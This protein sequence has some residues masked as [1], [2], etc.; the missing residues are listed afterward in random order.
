MILAAIE[1]DFKNKKANK[2][3]INFNKIRKFHE[4]FVS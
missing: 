1:W 4:C 2:D 3:F